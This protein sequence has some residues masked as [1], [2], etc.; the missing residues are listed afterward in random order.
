MAK[1]KQESQAVSISAPNLKTVN[2]RVKGTS[3][4]VQERFDPKV[5]QQMADKQEQ[6]EQTVRKPKR[7]PKDLE[8]CYQGAMY[9]PVG[10]TWPNGAIPATQFKAAM[11]AA[12]RLI[13]FKM[14]ESKQ[15]VYVEP[16]G[17][18]SDCIP[19]VKISK[20]KPERFEQALKNANGNPDIRVR[21][22]WSPGWEVILRVTY[23]ADRFKLEDVANLLMR[24][25]TQ[26]GIGAGRHAS[27]KCCGLG[28]GAFSITTKK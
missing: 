15:C 1:K 2:F 8:A 12:C 9:K 22:K 23:D 13:D 14:T 5:R 7:Q 20:G 21:P 28:W 18:D 25:G 11:V 26:V 19:L 24:A 16:D 6:G 4:Y 3:P 17:Y 10:E 27:R